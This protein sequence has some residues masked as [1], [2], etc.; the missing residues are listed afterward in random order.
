MSLS[1]QGWETASVLLWLFLSAHT[2]VLRLKL[3]PTAARNR[4][5]KMPDFLTASR[6]LFNIKPRCPFFFFFSILSPTLP[7]PPE[8]LL[9]PLHSCF[10][11][12]SLLLCGSSTS[13]AA[14]RD[15]HQAVLRKE[16]RSSQLLGWWHSHLHVPRGAPGLGT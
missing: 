4:S 5:T 16:S 2:A 1:F 10:L 6:S 15:P 3:V 9:L 7:P 12:L 8:N 13:S 11:K 14:W